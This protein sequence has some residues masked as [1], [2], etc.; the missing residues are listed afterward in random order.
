MGG[1]VIFRLYALGQ[2]NIHLP[3]ELP[4]SGKGV[5]QGKII[6]QKT[7]QAGCPRRGEQVE[8]KGSLFPH[9]R[10]NGLYQPVVK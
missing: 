10:V 1:V 3:D 4:C 9:M 8:Q 5:G 2:I 7:Q 6:V